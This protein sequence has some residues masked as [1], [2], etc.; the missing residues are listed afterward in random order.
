MR[1]L[2]HGDVQEVQ[3]NG[4]VAPEHVPARDEEAERVRD[5]A[6]G[7]RDQHARRGDITGGHDR[8]TKI[9]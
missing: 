3:D 5:L 6:G 4:A 2:H 7:A 1:Y 9:T 8:R